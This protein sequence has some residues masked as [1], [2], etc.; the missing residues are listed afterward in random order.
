MRNWLL[1]YAQSN[2]SNGKNEYEVDTWGVQQIT[3]HWL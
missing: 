3:V 1:L 2:A